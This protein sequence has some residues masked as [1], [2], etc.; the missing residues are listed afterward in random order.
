MLPR[1]LVTSRLS[2]SVLFIPAGNRSLLGPLNP[3]QT[4]S[5]STAAKQPKLLQLE[6]ND[7]RVIVPEGSTI[8]QACA[9]IGIQIP[10]F[11]YHERLSIAGT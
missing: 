7:Q 5:N 10:R 2:S 6:I 8:I 11:C 4:R 3:I 9:S 1:H